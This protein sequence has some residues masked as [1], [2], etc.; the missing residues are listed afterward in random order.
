MRKKRPFL[1]ALKTNLLYDVALL[2]NL[3]IEVPFGRKREWSALIEGNWSWWDTGANRY[4][5][6]RI[7]VAGVELRRWLPSLYCNCDNTTPL[8]GWYIGA[9]CYGGD[10]D[11]R[12]FADQNSDLGQQSLWTYSAG[13]TAG[14]SLIIGKRF[15]LAFGI[16][17]GYI[18]GEYSKY[19]VSECKEGVFPRVSR[20]ER[21]YFG[22]TKAEVSLV[23][24]IGKA[25]NRSKGKEASR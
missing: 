7:Q 22:V 13:L 23:W 2:P 21:N 11:I 15:N 20:H 4:N 19:N 6:H 8:T 14:Y 18:G 16:G 10:Y 24:L 12:L 9:Y 1:I 25:L 17:A 5:Y 3:S